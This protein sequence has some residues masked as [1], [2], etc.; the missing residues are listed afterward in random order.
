MAGN[1]FQ[2]DAFQYT[3]FQHYVIPAS[4]LRN[5]SRAEPIYLVDVTLKNSGPILHFSDRN[6]LVNVQQY[7]NYIKDISGIEGEI[8]RVDSA[9]LNTD[10]T[11]TFKNDR[12]ASYDYLIEIG[13]TYPFEGAEC[14]IKEVY[15]DNDDNP[16]DIVTIFKGVID[17]PQEIDLLSFQCKV[18]SMMFQKD[19]LWQVGIIDIDTYP[20]AYEDVGKL[21]PFIYG[22]DI[23]IPAIRVD[24]GAK[25]TLQAAIQG[26]TVTGITLSDT[27]R[28]PASGTLLIDNEELSYTSIASNV[29]AGVTR[30]V[31]STTATVHNEGADIWEKQTNYDS[32]L[33][34]H[35]LHT[36]GDIYAEIDSKLWKVTSGAAGLVSGGKHY[37]RATSQIK[38]ER[39]I[40]NVAVSDN[41]TIYTSS[42]SNIILYPNATSDPWN[43][44]SADSS[45]IDN[46]LATYANDDYGGGITLSTLFPSTSYGTIATQHFHV[47]YSNP[48]GYNLGYRFNGAGAYTWLADTGG[49]ASTVQI[50]RTG[51]NWNDWMEFVNVYNIHNSRLYEVWKDVDYSATMYKTGSAYRAGDINNISFVD[52]FHATVS[53]YKDPDGN[54]GGV[55]SVIERPDYV[56]KHFLVQKLGFDIDDIDSTSFTAA[57]TWYGTNTY[58]FG[59]G[60]YDEI[61]PSEFLNRLAFE[62]RSTLRYI[63]GKWYLDVIPDTSPAAIKTISSSELAGKFSK[64]KFNKTSVVDIANYVTAVFKR[65]YSKAQAINSDWL[66]T[67]VNSDAISEG[68]YGTYPKDFE[69]EYIRDQTTADSVLAHILLQRAVPLLI[70]KFPV[71]WEHFDLKEGD[72]FDIDNLL[73]DAKKF[74]IEKFKRLDKFKAEIEAIEWYN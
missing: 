28:F 60:V 21:E 24:W 9:A 67:S 15:L 34:S 63:A 12:Y 17:E 30:G 14:L 44:W 48:T 7:E 31:N 52:R 3:A 74:F 5:R 40:D 19:R 65:D 13:D 18:S 10:I 73:Y 27:T 45:A 2:Q 54:Y 36:I 51:G 38:T 29:L 42:L 59:F 55:G 61:V 57:G 6:I 66:L 23:L 50:N 1:A 62:C 16:S 69:F 64:F 68:K 8:S 32:L 53:G 49:A 4:T 25:T 37:L 26:D 35:E 47:K 56:I 22:S 58:K 43:G 20:E 72:T 11:I 71:F 33:A 46:N 41:I 70:I 39:V